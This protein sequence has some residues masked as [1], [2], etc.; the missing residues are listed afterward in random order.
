MITIYKFELNT[1]AT[2]QK[3]LLYEGAE[4]IR[5]GL[6]PRGVSCIWAIVDTQMPRI[7]FDIYIMGTGQQLPDVKGLTYIG[8]FNADE[9]VWHVFRA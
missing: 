5:V 2:T 1:I 7:N 9:Y 8:S 4:I 3:L 6:D